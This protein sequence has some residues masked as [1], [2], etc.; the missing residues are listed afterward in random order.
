[1]SYI[2]EIRVAGKEDFGTIT[3]EEIIRACIENNVTRIN[4]MSSQWRFVNK[5]TGESILGTISARE[6]YPESKWDMEH[7]DK[8]EFDVN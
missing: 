4:S 5:E 7:T 3:P 8:W 2:F 6:D 1:M